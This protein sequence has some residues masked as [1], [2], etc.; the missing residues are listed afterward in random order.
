MHIPGTGSRR[1][2]SAVNTQVHCCIVKLSNQ[3][4]KHGTQA[5]KYSLI[6]EETFKDCVISKRSCTEFYLSFISHFMYTYSAFS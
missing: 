3:A 4:M 1:N 2:N 6:N 5:M